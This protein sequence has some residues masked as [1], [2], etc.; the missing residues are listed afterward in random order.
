MLAYPHIDPVALQLG[1]IAIRWY[2]LAYLTGIFAGWKLVWTFNR[3]VTPPTLSVDAYENIIT[4]AVL[5]I[6]LGGRCGYVFFYKP[7][8]YLSHPLEALMLWHG[9]MSFHGGLLGTI[10][11]MALFARKYHSP[12][13]G[14]TDLLAIVAPI[15]LFFG[16][17][18]N[19]INGELYGRVTSSDFAMIFPT[20]PDHLP[21][22]PSQLYEA[23]LE[24][25]LLFSVILLIATFT[26][27]LRHTG[28]MSGI[29]LIGYAAARITAE[30]FREPDAFLGFLAGGLTMGQLLCIPMFLIG[31]ILVIRRDTRSQLA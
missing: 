22:H 14:V 11:A 18:A 19:F 25:L 28:K 7:D 1:P 30:C 6:I 16:R 10:V 5:G 27:T 12:F 3:S 15:G 24:G 23:T 26:R 21:R 2:A 29:F 13:L 9:G 4:Y 8:F 31:L 20:D 17:V